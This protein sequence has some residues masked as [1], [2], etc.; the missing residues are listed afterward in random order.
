MSILYLNLFLCKWL[1]TSPQKIL[2]H[3]SQIPR[4][5]KTHYHQSGKKTPFN[6]NVFFFFFSYDLEENCLQYLSWCLFD[7]RT[8]VFIFTD[9]ACL[10]TD[11]KIMNKL[12]WMCYCTRSYCVDE[13]CCSTTFNV[14]LL[15]FSF[16]FF[17]I[18]F[19]LSYSFSTLTFYLI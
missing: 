13:I 10:G 9:S 3:S 7:C 14:I 11:K 12:P 5:L 1:Y 16:F 15:V 4:R 18:I 8:N 19:F 6:L 17:N 2:I